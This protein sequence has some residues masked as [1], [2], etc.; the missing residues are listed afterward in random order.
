MLRCVACTFL[1]FLFAARAHDLRAQTSAFTVRGIVIDS[2]TK[3]PLFG[4]SVAL[5]DA[6]GKLRGSTTADAQGMFSLEKIPAG[7]YKVIVSL[8]GYNKQIIN[9]ITV[10]S[11]NNSLPAIALHSSLTNI[12]EV[13]VAGSKTQGDNEPVNTM[14]VISA[15]SFTI[16]ES[17]KVA[18]SL[19]D[20]SRLALSYAGVRGQSDILNGIVVRGNAPKGVMWRV[21]GVEV[22]SPNHFSQE[23]Y[24][25]GAVCMV[26]GQVTGASDFYSGAF[27]AEYGNA[28]SAVFDIKMKKADVSKRH[29]FMQIG[30]MGLEAGTHGPF[31]KGKNATYLLNYRYSTLAVFE[32]IGM[33]IGNTITSYQ[34]LALKMNF[35]TKKAGTFSVF[36]VSGKSAIDI[37]EEN[38][39]KSKREEKLKTYEMAFYGIS[40][41]YSLSAKHLLKTTVLVAANREKLIK[42][43]F[44]YRTSQMR[45]DYRLRGSNLYFR[46]VAQVDS[47]LSQRS[48][49]RSGIIASNLRFKLDDVYDASR[50]AIE[51]KST[52]ITYLL[53]ALTQWKY[54]LA[55]KW[56]LHTGMHFLF[57]GLNRH[58]N[59]EPRI[60]LAWQINPKQSLA[61]A[62]GL[63][64]KLEALANYLV[65][66]P[67]TGSR[68]NENLNFT[69]AAHTG[70]SYEITPAR[71][72]KLKTE[73]YFQYLYAVPVS[74]DEG[75]SFSM[76]NMQDRYVTMPLVNTGKGMNYGVELT[77]EKSFADNYYII[78]N[79]SLFQSTYYAADGIWRNS[80]YN[81]NFITSLTAGKDVVFGKTK[82]W[83]FGVNGRALW[84]GGER[85]ELTHFEEQIAN[86]FRVDTRVS[87]ARKRDL[88]KWT[89]A[90]DIQNATNRINE[91]TLDEI[92]SSGILPVMSFRVEL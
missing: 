14:A 31:V 89:L 7:D 58:F 45:P 60:A 3:E 48:T 10:P 36:S 82:Q 47:R 29:Y 1:L 51:Y 84:S 79:G 30:M 27:P 16:E 21:E 12:N 23:G 86:Y 38:Q 19:G 20:P 50:S 44:F 78:A 46:S 83:T 59:F 9:K 26:S 77:V 74:T 71:H 70:I 54:A 61:F 76:L 8:I 25:A 80:R 49:L 81:S 4:A 6:A 15:R 11:A 35:P 72:L 90:L 32:K 69:K 55:E 43:E 42:D 56:T 34:D 37:S 18:A 88:V 67:F 57:F 68:P 41:H 73:L 85:T 52:G 75:S 62:A 13:V 24:G 53:Q 17:E 22:P 2:D 92:E 66:D 91:T 64:S 5:E 39:R 63:H 65:H 87:I 28:M 33:D 40:N